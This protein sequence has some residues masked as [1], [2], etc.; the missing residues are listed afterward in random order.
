MLSEGF[1]YIKL[2][3]VHNA[4]LEAWKDLWMVHT[5][6]KQLAGLSKAVVLE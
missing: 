4:N 2:K 6:Q 1:M 3:H 5:E